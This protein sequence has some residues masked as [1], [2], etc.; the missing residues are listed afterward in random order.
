MSAESFRELSMMLSIFSIDVEVDRALDS[1]AGSIILEDDAA[2][3]DFLEFL[4][5]FLVVFFYEF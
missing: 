5:F 2:G 3:A 4:F 1:F